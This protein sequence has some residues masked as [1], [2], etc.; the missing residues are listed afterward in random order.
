[1]KVIGIDIGGTNITAAL[2]KHE[3]VIRTTKIDT[4]SHRNEEEI[5]KDLF[6]AV[7]DVITNDTQAIGIGVPGVIDTR[8]GIIHE[9]IN[10]PCWKDYPLKEKVEKK[11]GL[12]VVIENDANCYVLAVHRF[13]SGKS[14]R[15]IIGIS[16]GTGLG[17]GI[18]IDG[19]L[20]TGIN[21]GAGEF[22]QL[23]YKKGIYEDYCSGKFFSSGTDISGADNYQRAIDGDKKALDCW[24]E[25]GKHIAELLQVVIYALAP[26]MIAFGGSVSKGFDFFKSSMQE[27]LNKFYLQGIISNT[28]IGI[29]NNPQNPLLG[30]AALCYEAS[31]EKY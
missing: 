5:L 25:F 29:D 24:N 4:L 22:G 12:P 3:G 8:K 18:I 31:G 28:C 2:V 1:M 27:A 10:I 21:S 23:P 16:L 20:Y 19:K 11:F 9:I 26:E 7:N 15:N 30:A 13:G 17:T 6:C 14:Y